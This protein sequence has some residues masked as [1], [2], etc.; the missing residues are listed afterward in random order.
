MVKKPG[1][2]LLQLGSPTAPTPKAVYKFLVEFLNDPLVIDIPWLAR[3]A[4]VRGIIA[5]LR[6][7]RVAEAYSSIWTNEGSPLIVHTQSFADKVKNIL[8]RRFD[9]RWAL[10]YGQPSIEGRLTDWDIDELFIVP[11]Y[12]QYALSSS[13]TAIDKVKEVLRKQGREVRLR[14]LR[15][16]FNEPEFIHS[17]TLTIQAAAGEFKP[18]HYLMSFHGLP[19][20]HVTKL[21][22]KR[23][24]V[25]PG[26]CEK[27][28]KSNRW[29]Y[30]AQSMATARALKAALNISAEEMTVGFQSRLGNRPWIQPFTDQILPRLVEDGVR[31]LLVT[32]PSFVS[33]CL[34]TLEEVQ[35]RLREQFLS[36]GGT[37][38]ILVPS[39]NSQDYWVDDFCQMITRHN[40]H[41][42]ES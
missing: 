28:G 40:L 21:H 2:L 11:L 17:Q 13:Q 15:D 6:S 12:P 31:R 16:F 7:R 24:L 26:C 5:P 1:L 30:R 39:L 23:C 35:I 41:W 38:L 4:L 32:C 25:K 36:L 14:V 37:D 42:W 19:E 33:D 27:V 29:C 8:D 3:Q 34:E 9:V 20:H 10:R 22:P 18:D